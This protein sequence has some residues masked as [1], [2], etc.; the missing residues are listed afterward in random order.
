MWQFNLKTGSFQNGMSVKC[1]KIICWF[2]NAIWFRPF[3]FGMLWLRHFSR[4]NQVQFYDPFH[5]RL[6]SF[7]FFNLGPWNK[8]IQTGKRAVQNVT[9][10]WIWKKMKLKGFV[11]RAF[12]NGYY[13]QHMPSSYAWKRPFRLKNHS[14]WSVLVCIFYHTRG[15]RYFRRDHV[16]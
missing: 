12:K 2:W 1:G 4:G 13:I 10:C 5:L 11:F 8:L 14:A 3:G 16:R 15:V 6:K 7:N 9:K